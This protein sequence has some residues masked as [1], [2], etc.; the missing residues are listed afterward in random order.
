MRKGLFGLGLLNIELRR[1]EEERRKKD[2][3]YLSDAI[4]DIKKA[5]EV[6]LCK[7]CAEELGKIEEKARKLRDAWVKAEG[8]SKVIELRKK[9]F[10]EE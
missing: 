6:A 2:Y 5:K 9:F 4:E 3:E 8:S 7:T 1:H 10:K